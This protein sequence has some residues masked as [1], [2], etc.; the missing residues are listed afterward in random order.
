MVGKTI[1]HYT[2]LEKLGEGGMGVVYK[3][4]DT[5]LERIVALKLL[6]PEI[7]GDQEATK[8]FI[9]EARAASALNHP[10]ITT[11]YEI[12]D[13]HGRDYICMEYLEGQTVKVK[14]KSNP[15]P[16]DDVLD[17]AIQ[18]A[19]A[20]Q[21]AHAQD[22]IHRDI[23]SENIMVTPR[24]QVK[25][26]DFGLAKL[27]GTTTLTKDGSTM[28]TIAYMSPEQTQGENVDQRTDIWSFGVVLYEMITGQLPFR[29]D[30]DQ[31]VIYS[32]L[33][34]EPEAMVRLREDVPIELEQIV[35]QA[36]T[37]NPNERYENI[38]SMIED[39]NPPKNRFGTKK[40]R[41][42]SKPQKNVQS[43][44]IY[45]LASVIVIIAISLVLR[46]TFLSDKID[47]IAVLPFEDFSKDI[48]QEYFTDGITDTLITELSKIS[49]LRVISRTSVMQ[50]KKESKSLA[51]I[52]EEL[53]V[54]AVVEGSIS[55]EG[56]KVR[57]S[58]RLIKTMP[59]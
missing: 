2:I 48:K 51:Q 4:L 53:N 17:I 3:A 15:L 49:A 28:G 41:R 52:A 58:A 6:R 42:N 31:A 34:E 27:K 47:S 1:S 59:D 35:N 40:S 43:K 22:I 33:N 29:G 30:Y 24:G 26:M 23:K 32:I 7:M 36:L 10:N 12:G 11:I 9:R 14:V 46:P 13:W 25:L 18:T 55:R 57:I 16:I 44:L 21:E 56:D 37:K 38:S 19:E 50:Y 54:D 5:K 8:R 20:L 39:L 45:S